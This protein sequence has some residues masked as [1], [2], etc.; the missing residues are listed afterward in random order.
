[1]RRLYHY[2]LSPFSRRVRLALA[3]KGL[4]ATLVDPRSEPERRSEVHTLN[5][6]RTV[7]VLV[8]EGGFAIGD[9]LAIT[10]Y[11]DAA[12]P[13]R[14]VWPTAAEELGRDLRI[15]ALVD[16]ALHTVVDLGTRYHLLSTSETWRSVA[17]EMMTRVQSAL[18][19]VG[20][21]VADLPAQRW[22]AAEMWLTTAV[23]WL[24]GLPARAAT[25]PP[26]A[27]IVGLGW[28]VPAALSAWATPHLGRAEVRALG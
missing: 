13:D 25:F 27:H 4:E 17:A 6:L 2:P 8:E 22:S 19:E 16:G 9:S 11:L 5:P 7:P 15:T 18:D 10:R 14:P 21:T 28:S 3:H 24:E 26:A 12:Y 20:R 1:M 23:A